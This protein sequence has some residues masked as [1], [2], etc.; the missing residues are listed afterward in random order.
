MTELQ[1][2]ILEASND[3]LITFEEASMMLTMYESGSF[4]DKV[5]KAWEAFKKW[6][7][8]IIDKITKKA[9]EFKEKIFGKKEAKV[10]VKSDP[11]KV[12]N[13]L[14]DVNSHLKPSEDF[15]GSFWEK[16]KGKAAIAAIVGVAGGAVTITAVEAHKHAEE[17]RDLL[18]QLN[19]K[20]ENFKCSDKLS[21][22]N[23]EFSEDDSIIE[24][25]PKKGAAVINI[26]ASIVRPIISFAQS[27]LISL[28]II[29]NKKDEEITKVSDDKEA[30]IHK[31]TQNDIEIDKIGNEN[32]ELKERR[33]KL[34][35]EYDQL[36]KSET[37]SSDQ[38]DAIC[39]KIK[40]CDDKYQA[41]CDRMKNIM[42]NE[43]LRKD[44][45]DH[46][47]IFDDYAEY[48]YNNFKSIARG[49]IV[50]LNVLLRKVKKAHKSKNIDE[51]ELLIKDF[52]HDYNNA[53][54]HLRNVHVE[55]FGRKKVA[56]DIIKKINEACDNYERTIDDL[57]NK[58]SEYNS[59]EDADEN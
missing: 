49:Y 1:Y 34:Q 56:D 3:D 50:R 8:D 54:E 19:N 5:K 23:V 33:S 57:N 43:S 45:D 35:A 46:M 17:I 53:K 16:I 4:G 51:L 15:N 29:T 21:P 24:M 6:V 44:F 18:I 10:T 2:T 27:F 7:K 39:K 41:N 28:L 37:A 25:T 14:K 26:V 36:C 58:C 59:I 22:F 32:A 20:L 9:V 30:D 55:C 11:K 13:L 52:E 40:K 31:P 12:K 42:S 48:S 38:I 47:K